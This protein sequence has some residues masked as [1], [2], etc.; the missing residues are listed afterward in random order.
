MDSS[1]S[2]PTTLVRVVALGFTDV[3]LLLLLLVVCFFVLPK[4][5]FRALTRSR[6]VK[7]D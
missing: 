5:V 4:K 1:T 6:A 3:L 7:H 2:S